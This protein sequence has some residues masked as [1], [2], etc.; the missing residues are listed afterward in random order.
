MRQVYGLFGLAVLV[1][2]GP[3][4]PTIIPVSGTVTLD[5][6]PLPRAAVTFRPDGD[7]PGVGG[8]A[9]TGPDGKYQVV[10]RDGKGLAPGP[11][12]VIVNRPLRKDGVPPPPDVPPIESD[13][14]ETLPLIYT[15]A[16]H[17]VLR[18]TIRADGPPVDLALESKKK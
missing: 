9:V 7:T 13:A 18:A 17:T 5:G 3:A 14:T 6:T 8:S 2:C 11:Y 10:G 1:G 12:K 15:S 4:G 16:E